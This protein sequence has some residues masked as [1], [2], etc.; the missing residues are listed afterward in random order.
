[1]SLDQIIREEARLII[2][3]ELSEQANYSL[4][5]TLLQAVLEQFAISRSR[6]WIREELR[7]LAELGAVTLSQAGSVTVARLTDKGAD[8][9]AGRLRIEGVKRR[10]P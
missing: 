3:R 5:E 6:E 10:A 8:H 4:G 7:C 9:V 1:M 2:L